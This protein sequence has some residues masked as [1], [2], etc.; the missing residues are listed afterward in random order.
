MEEEKNYWIC[1]GNSEN[2]N[3][4]KEYQIWG[5]S[6]HHRNIIGKVREGDFLVFYTI[7]EKK[8]GEV[9]QPQLRGVYKASSNPFT[10]YTKVFKHVGAELFPHRV[11]LEPVYAPENPVPF[12]KLIPKLEFITNKKRWH[13]H[14]FGRAMRKISKKDFET[15]FSALKGNGN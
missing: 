11:Q 8:E 13:T 10:G 5:V 7:M 3:I 12:K 4:T 2:W 1:I 9:I 6:E 14:L 15:I